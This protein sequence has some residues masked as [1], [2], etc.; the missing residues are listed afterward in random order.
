[1]LCVVIKI[2]EFCFYLCE[3]ASIV[4]NVHVNWY[5]TVKMEAQM[6]LFKSD[7]KLW[8][9]LLSRKIVKLKY[10]LNG[11]W[12]FLNFQ[13]WLTFPIKYGYTRKDSSTI[14]WSD[15]LPSHVIYVEHFYSVIYVFG[16]GP[17]TLIKFP[18]RST[19]LTI[20]RWMW[21]IVHF[22]LCSSSYNT[23]W[24]ILVAGYLNL[25]LNGSP[26]NYYK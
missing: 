14:H 24:H 25:Y 7:L 17:S 26:K 11:I 20:V 19:F 4:V 16:S 1:M 10:E 12:F 5:C 23:Y 22:L 8:N 3:S 6:N 9:S 13:T 2:I 21:K 15:L 18:L